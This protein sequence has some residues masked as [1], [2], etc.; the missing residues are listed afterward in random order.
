KLS[1]TEVKELILNNVD[2]VTQLHNYCLTGG[3]LNA[4]KAVKAATESATFVKD[5][6]GDGKDDMILVRKSNGKYAFSVFKGQTSGYLSSPVTTTTTRDFSYDEEVFCGDFNGDGKAD[7]LLHYAVN[8]YRH[9]SLFLGKSNATFEDEE[10]IT[11]TRYHDEMLYPY[12]AFIGDQ[13]GDGKD[14]FILV[15]ENSYYNV[16]ILVYRGATSPYYL[17]DATSTYSS[18]IQYNHDV[19]MFSGCFNDDNKT[20]ILIHSKSSTNKHVL[21]TFIS[22]SAC[23]FTC[24]TLTST[25]AVDKENHPFKLLIGDQNG[26][27]QDDFIVV[28]KGS[29]GYRCG[30]VYK[31]DCYTPYFIDGSILLSSFDNYD[32]KDYAFSGDFNGDGFSDILIERGY[33]GYRQLITYKANITGSYDSAISQTTTNGYNRKTWPATSLV[34]DINGDG[35]DD[36]IVKW[37]YATDDEVSVHVYLGGTN[38]FTTANTTHS[39]IPFYNE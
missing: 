8:S 17:L 12:K 35:K 33:N 24:A 25:Y 19:E 38:G 13:N 30:L 2:D 20:D 16:G 10:E 11:S 36:F 34:G 9:F 7:I 18:S 6:T 29:I 39:S 5:I 31:G 23:D 37:K 3:R 4:Y 26:D 28:Y 27:S 22:T 1:A 21:C 15:Y 32:N 14:D